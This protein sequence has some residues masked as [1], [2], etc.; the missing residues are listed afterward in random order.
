MTR[1]AV[2]VLLVDDDIDVLDSLEVLVTASPRLR[3]A[4]R[5]AS[6]HEALQHCQLNH[7]EVVLADIRMPGPDG[8]TLTRALTR[9]DRRNYPRV[10]VTTAFPLDEYLLAALGGGA[11]GFLAKGAPWP[12]VHDALLTVADGGIALPPTLTARVID[13]T[14]PGRANLATLTERELQVLTLVGSGHDLAAIATT[15]FVSEHTV[16]AHL[17]HLRAKLA[18][19]TR[20]DLAIAARQAGL[21]HLPPHPTAPT[22]KPHP[23]N[24]DR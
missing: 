12:D 13:L 15:L 8:L 24:T 6:T 3:L 19:R 18:V 7:P 2:S 10:L 5:A 23:P 11:S 9:G 17:E 14:L 20:A 22:Q 4:G 16:R 1:S 21:G